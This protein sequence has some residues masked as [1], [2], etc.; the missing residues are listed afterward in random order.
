MDSFELN[1]LAM[2]VL[3]A[4]VVAMSLSLGVN[5]FYQGAK[6]HDDGHGGEVK[7]GYQIEVT[8]ESPAGG[9]AAEVKSPDI[10]GFF[11]SASLDKGVNL[12]KACAAC[13]SF[14]DGG[15]HKVGPRL[16]DIVGSKIAR[17]KDYSYS[18]ALAAKGGNWGYQEL[19][20][21]LEK[22]RNYVSGTKMAY[23]GMKKPEDRASI[24]L[25]LRSLSASPKPL[26]EV[27][28]VEVKADEKA[29]IK[30]DAGDK[31]EEKTSEKAP[32]KVETKK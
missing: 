7:R 25:Y 15:A 13:H 9:A 27:K 24:L 6:S 31:A 1:K 12:S 28:A 32:K 18:N 16:Y 30:S 26:P 2:A 14:E 8:E 20:E 3:V 21:F 5:G 4:G 23:A 11:A 10:A 17:H 22:P 29:E 19:S